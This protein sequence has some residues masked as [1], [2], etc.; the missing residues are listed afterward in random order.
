VAQLAETY[1]HLRPYDVTKPRLGELGE[2]L[3]EVAHTAARVIYRGNVSIDVDLEGGSL[4][5]W[6]TVAGIISG[7][8]VGYGI[9]ADY[10]GFRGVLLSF[11]N[12]L[13]NLVSMSAVASRKSWVHPSGKSIV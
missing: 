3:Q 13:A 8:H 2:Y 7:A 5:V 11:A 1:I 4:K 6:V 10:K 12:M 9:V